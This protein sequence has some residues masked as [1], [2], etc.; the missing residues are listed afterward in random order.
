M[1]VRLKI[2]IGLLVTISALFGAEAFLAPGYREKW[3]V[4]VTFLL[5]TA[6]LLPMA[7]LLSRWLGLAS[8]I[9]LIG[10]SLFQIYVVMDG[11]E[12]LPAL[13]SDITP[14]DRI[15]ILLPALYFVFGL[16][17]HMLL[18]HPS[19]RLYFKKHRNPEQAN[20]PAIA[21]PDAHGL[22]G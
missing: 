10:C 8:V 5:F 17:A 16:L 4:A 19:V 21:P 3:E 13:V 14:L 20:T 12:N 1:P 22:L 18:W 2:L 7:T 6:Y 9:Y 11:W 15:L